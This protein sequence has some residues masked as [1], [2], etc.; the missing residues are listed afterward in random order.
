MSPQ[1]ASSA[2]TWE[3]EMAEVDEECERQALPPPIHPFVEAQKKRR[4]LQ[5]KRLS[6]GK[7]NNRGLLMG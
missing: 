5:K 1:T 7:G 3:K 6:N 2:G 4:Q